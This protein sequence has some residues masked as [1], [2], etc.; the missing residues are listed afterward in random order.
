[1]RPK[2]E[3]EIVARVEAKVHARAFTYTRQ[4]GRET[5]RHIRTHTWHIELAGFRCAL[6]KSMLSFR[7]AGP[8]DTTNVSVCV[9]SPILHC[10]RPD[11]RYNHFQYW[12]VCVSGGC[13]CFHFWHHNAAKQWRQ[14]RSHWRVAQMENI[15][16]IFDA[17]QQTC[18]L[19]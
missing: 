8:K 13:Y 4:R 3:K 11:F 9:C 10:M 5:E 12:I 17:K 7:L 2:N 6:I 14:Y 15:D 19:K 16:R 18:T 1:M